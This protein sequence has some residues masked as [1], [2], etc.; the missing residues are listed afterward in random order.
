M[1]LIPDHTEYQQFMLN[2]LDDRNMSGVLVLLDNREQVVRP[3]EIREDAYL[4]H[5]VYNIIRK[6]GAYRPR[7]S[8]E[9]VA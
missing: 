5:R 3:D 4:A 7:A 9:A 2:W 8:D 6:S 1:N